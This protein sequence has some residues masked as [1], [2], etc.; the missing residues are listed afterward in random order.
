MLSKRNREARARIREHNPTKLARLALSRQATE[1]A[2]RAAQLV[3]TVSDEWGHACEWLEPAVGTLQ[4]AELLVK[5]AVVFERARGTT[6]EQIGDFL[7]ITKQSAQAKYGPAVAEWEADLFAPYGLDDD[8]ERF[9]RL[10]DLPGA[11]L[12]PE[13]YGPELDSWALRWRRHMEEREVETET[14]VTGNL[15]ADALRDKVSVILAEAR[16]AS[17]HRQLGDLEYMAGYLEWKAGVYDALQAADDEPAPRGA[18]SYAEI[19]AGAR[20]HAAEM[21]AKLTEQETHQ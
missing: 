11:V 16:W 4:D 2:E 14:P 17:E 19:A 15:P 18:S 10:S 1:V 8:G 3:P 9:G 21:R 13:V 12:E 7:G 20:A 5:R 6:W